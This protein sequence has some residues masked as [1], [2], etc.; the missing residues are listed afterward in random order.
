MS[1]CRVTEDGEA[2]VC[3]PTADGASWGSSSCL[4]R[5]EGWFSPMVRK[6]R[7]QVPSSSVTA[8]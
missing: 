4:A 3:R 2:D 1:T 5:G 8:E 7:L 6:S